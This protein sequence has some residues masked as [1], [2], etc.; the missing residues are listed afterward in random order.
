MNVGCFVCKNQSQTVGY[1]AATRYFR[2]M[3]A[4]LELPTSH[5]LVVAV[6]KGIDRV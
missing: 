5:C 2:K 6:G 1:L 3:F 4:V